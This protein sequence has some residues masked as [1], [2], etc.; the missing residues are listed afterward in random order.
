MLDAAAHCT[1]CNHAYRIQGGILRL[2]APTALDAES[3][4]ERVVRNEQ[5]AVAD[6]TWESD[7]WMQKEIV[8][9][10]K[11]SEPLKSASVLELGAGAGRYS[12]L[13]AERG[14]RLMATDFSFVALASLAKR[15]KPDWSIG[16]IEADCTQLQVR[17]NFDLVASTLMSNLPTL[18]HR[19]ALYKVVA[20]ALREGGKFVFST[21]HFSWQ[22]RLARKARSGYYREGGIY[23]YMFEV[24]EIRR[25]VAQHF[26]S[27]SCRPI[28]IHI[29][30]AGKFG[31]ALMLSRLSERIWPL[32]RLGELLLVS[33]RRPIRKLMA[34]V[35][36]HLVIPD[37]LYV[38]ELATV[39]L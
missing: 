37:A 18:E 28:Q 39:V 1:D 12:V 29:P 4:H 27:V 35:C 6:H 3:A 17:R 10:L 24:A 32:N 20:N 30:L 25:E 26:E 13:M 36:L 8:P 31:A 7:A 19:R 33:A 16:L 9:T 34:F 38:A 15:V 23:R 2:L 5:A 14:A 22:A 11:E 21:H